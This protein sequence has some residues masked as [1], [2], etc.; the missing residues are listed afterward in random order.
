MSVGS[1]GIQEPLDTS[2]FMT[3]CG[4]NIVNSL[5]NERH[6][7]FEIQDGRYMLLVL[8]VSFIKVLKKYHLSVAFIAFAYKNLAR[9][10]DTGK[11]VHTLPH[12]LLE[13][14]Y[15]T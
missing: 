5:R 4:E 2:N 8:L 10:N 3:E 1:H 11:F 15:S 9:I 12:F 7:Y 6:H 14:Y 13:T